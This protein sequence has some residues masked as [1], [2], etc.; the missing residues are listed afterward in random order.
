MFLCSTIFVVIVEKHY[1]HPKNPARATLKLKLKGVGQKVS[2]V[3]EGLCQVRWLIDFGR[4]PLLLPSGIFVSYR[5]EPNLIETT[6]DLD[7]DGN[8]EPAI[9][10]A[11]PG[12]YFSNKSM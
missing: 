6:K 8:E 12:D 5:N 3:F 7:L 9:T 1:S 10:A 11:V 2:H 4:Y